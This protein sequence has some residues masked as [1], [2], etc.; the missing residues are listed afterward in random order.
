MIYSMCTI[1]QVSENPSMPCTRR[2]HEPSTK[3]RTEKKRRR[4]A[5]KIFRRH[6]LRSLPRSFDHHTQRYVHLRNV[7]CHF[8]HRRFA[9]ASRYSLGTASRHDS[10]FVPNTLSERM[11]CFKRY[12]H[13]HFRQRLSERMICFKR[14]WHARFRQR[15]S[16]RTFHC[17]RYWHARFGRAFVGTH[18]LP[19]ASLARMVCLERYWHARFG[20][21]TADTS[22]Q[23]GSGARPKCLGRVHPA[24][25]GLRPLWQKSGAAEGGQRP[26][27]S[28]PTHAS[29]ALLS[30]KMQLGC[31]ARFAEFSPHS[32]ALGFVRNPSLFRET[33]CNR[34]FSRKQSLRESQPP[35]SSP[36]LGLLTGGVKSLHTPS[37]QSLC[38]HRQGSVFWCGLLPQ[39]LAG[40][41]RQLLLRLFPQPKMPCG[42]YTA[43]ISL[44]VGDDKAM[45]PVAPL[46]LSGRSVCRVGPQSP[47]AASLSNGRRRRKIAPRKSAANA[48]LLPAGLARSMRR[49]SRRPLLR[50]APSGRGPGSFGPYP[51][52]TSLGHSCS[53]RALLTPRVF[54]LPKQ[55][56]PKL[57]GLRGPR[58]NDI[59]P[60]VG[61][62][63]RITDLINRLTG[64]TCTKTAA[65]V[66][67]NHQLRHNHRPIQQRILR[68]PRALKNDVVKSCPFYH[69][70]F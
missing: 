38:T 2:N 50:S 35:P 21:V 45:L 33:H 42:G 27:Y 14:Y 36:P 64:Q 37:T 11:I 46:A 55:T 67:R 24:F 9:G 25:A 30:P 41:A 3:N 29:A 57:G 20:N 56:I 68:P 31:Y 44:S 18:D 66:R 22:K 51:G 40:S 63:R 48:G 62:K 7:R 17:Q 52:Q 69:N 5:K 10:P 8:F 16:E 34:A 43:R 12:W 47:P 13:A 54:C 60:T 26:P 39:T 70:N 4:T 32:T 6:Y 19:R 58:I 65:S 53:H 1:V 28:F 59:T 15:L 23:P 49:L 61:M